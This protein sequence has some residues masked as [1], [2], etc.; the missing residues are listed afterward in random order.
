MSKTSVDYNFSTMVIN[1][2][3][4]FNS[5][6]VLYKNNTMNASL[7]INMLSYVRRQCFI[8]SDS[9]NCQAKFMTQMNNSFG[10]GGMSTSFNDL[11]FCSFFQ[12]LKRPLL[13]ESN[14]KKAACI[15]GEQPCSNIWVLR[16]NLCMH[17]HRHKWCCDIGSPRQ[18]LKC[19]YIVGLHK[20]CRY[21]KTDLR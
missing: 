20:C 14:V 12:F 3:S 15:V 21:T 4:T 7:I 13:G 10:S 6:F 17:A 2:T 5:Y 16:P 8:T 11:H 9:S 18:Q 1:V 19:F